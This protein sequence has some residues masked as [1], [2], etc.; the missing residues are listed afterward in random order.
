METRKIILKRKSNSNLTEAASEYCR[1]TTIHGI[2]YIGAKELPWTERILWLIVIF[3]SLFF[4]AMLTFQI[5]KKIQTNSMIIGFSEKDNSVYE[6]PFPAVTICPEIKTRSYKL[7]YTDLYLKYIKGNNL[8]ENPIE[9]S[10][11]LEICKKT[12]KFKNFTNT[13]YSLDEY[14]NSLQ[15][16]GPEFKETIT[17]CGWLGEKEDCNQMLT[18]VLTEE[19]ICYTFN[20]LDKNEHFAK[21]V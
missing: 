17:E 12:P 18:K 9:F 15:E 6:I 5:F 3:L 4:C 11:L 2:K 21:D 8:P 10:S 19:G 7:N 20:G 14:V 16:I 1:N 13:R